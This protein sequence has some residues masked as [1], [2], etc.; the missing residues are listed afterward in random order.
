MSSKPRCSKSSRDS[1]GKR[2]ARGRSR[3]SVPTPLS[4]ETSDSEV[5]SASS[6]SPASR[7]AF[8]GVRRKRL[9]ERRRRRAISRGLS[10]RRRRA[11]QA[12]NGRCSRR[13]RPGPIGI[14]RATRE[15]SPRF[16][17]SGPGEPPPRQPAILE[18]A[19][20]RVLVTVHEGRALGTV[21][22]SSTSALRDVVEVPDLIEGARALDPAT[23]AIRPEGPALLQY[24]SGSTGD[25]KGVL[26]SHENLLSNIRAI[27]EAVKIGPSDVGVSWLPLYHD[28]G[29]IGAWLTPMFF[30]IPVAVLS[31]IAFLTRPERWLWTIH[32]RRGTISPAPNFAYELCARKISEAEIEGLDLSS[33]RAALNGAEPLSP[34]SLDRFEKKFAPCGVRKSSFFP[35]YGL[36]EGSLLLPA[37]VPG[38]EARIAAVD[39]G[40]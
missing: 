35:V 6:F 9:W 10:S 27:G 34:R 4:N 13:P 29:L 1:C 15:L 39:R 21:L 32:R 2:E 20:A 40:A 22:Q 38:A 28:M 24:T 30:G 26:L 23:I 33:W 5:S 7:P 12:M 18:N 36:A 19:Q 14:Q 16:S 11:F 17:R 25:P 3:P 37:P 31:P 8:A